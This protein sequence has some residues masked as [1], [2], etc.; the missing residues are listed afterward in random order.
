MPLKLVRIVKSPRP[1]KKWMAVFDK[2]GRTITTHFGAAGYASYEKHKD[3]KRRSRYLQR[4][5]ARENWN[6]PTSAGSLSRYILWGD[7]TSLKTNI[8]SFKRKFRL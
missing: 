2:D 8:A 4:H 5:R 6:D 7:S 3:K 1:Q